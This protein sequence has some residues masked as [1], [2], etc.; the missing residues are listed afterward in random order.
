[1]AAMF[2]DG[3]RRFDA[4]GRV[5]QRIGLMIEV[6]VHVLIVVVQHLSMFLVDD[7]IKTQ[8][9]LVVA[10]PL[11]EQF[12]HERLQFGDAHRRRNLLAHGRGAVEFERDVEQIR[13]NAKAFPRRLNDESTGRRDD[14]TG[15]ALPR[16]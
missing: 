11:C 5:L 14:G 12:A 6:E 8:R 4:D 9:L 2:N 1:M 7:K 15:G 3:S 13:P 16:W 10:Q